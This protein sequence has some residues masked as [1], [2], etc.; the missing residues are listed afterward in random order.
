VQILITGGAGFIGY[1]LIGALLDKDLDH[2]VIVLDDLSTGNVENIQDLQYRYGKRVELI[3]GN[4]LDVKTCSNAVLGCDIVFHLAAA[5]GVQLIMDEPIK[6]IKTNIEGTQN[7]LEACKNK[8]VILASTSEVYGNQLNRDG[9][10]AEDDKLTIGNPKV[11]RWSYACA[12][13]LDEWLALAYNTENHCNITVCRFFNTVGPRQSSQWGMVIP[14]FVKAAISN[15]PLKIHGDGK[16]LR[17]FAH[18]KD[19][20]ECLT[21]LMVSQKSYGEIVNIGSNTTISIEELASLVIALTNSKSDIIYTPYEEVYG[22]SFEDIKSRIPDTTKVK[23]LIGFSP[24]NRLSEIIEEVA[25]YE[26]S[27]RDNKTS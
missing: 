24:P 9:L 21:K 17:T 3:E 8:R 20:V 1:H 15:K 25:E 12:K 14:K 26:A 27:K 23:E 7:V 5:V 4:I 11:V 2:R 6:S 22:K 19:V 16:Q 18:V 13:A 10:M